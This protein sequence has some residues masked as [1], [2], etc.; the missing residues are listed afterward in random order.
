MGRAD[1][2]RTLKM[3]R[4]KAQVKKKI[5]EKAK[6]TDGKTPA[7]KKAAPA[8]AKKTVTRRPAAPATAT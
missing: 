2:R 3:R 5:R 4:K 6:I 1:N 7:V 8:A